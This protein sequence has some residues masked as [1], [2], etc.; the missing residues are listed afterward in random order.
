MCQACDITEP[1]IAGPR[2]SVAGR[3]VA[4]LSPYTKVAVLCAGLLVNLVAA[5]VMTSILLAGSCIVLALVVGTEPRLLAKRLVVP[6]Y[7]ASVAVAT[8]VFLS[9]ATPLFQLGPLT[10]YSEGLTQGILLGSRIAGGSALVLGFSLALSVT[11][12]MSLASRLRLSPVMIEIATL[13]Y[14]YLF[15]LA[16]EG[17]K[18]REAQVARL[19]HSS[20]RRSIQSYGTLI[21]M[22]M[23][24]SYDKAE[25]VYQA[26]SARGYTGSLP[27]GACKSL[28]AEDLLAGGGAMGFIAVIY[29]LGVA[30]GL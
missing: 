3:F 8:Q 11:E 15:L 30:N 26:M 12:L 22:V 20:W 25:A 28:V 6:W 27:I 21:G 1:G 10:G 13:T 7:I 19:G 2:G 14:R 16:E 9:G 24:R 18:I 23:A 4:G 17:Q 5:S 29:W